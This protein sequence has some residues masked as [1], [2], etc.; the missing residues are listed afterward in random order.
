MSPAL[1]GVYANG[2]IDWPRA[3]LVAL[4]L[5]VAIA[6]VVT[7]STST[8]AFSPYNGEWDGVADFRQQVEDDPDL[9]GVLLR[10]AR[11]YDALEADRT[12]AF[13]VAPEERYDLRETTAVR[14]F[15]ERGGTLVILENFGEPGTDL[16]TDVGANA[17]ITGD[18]VRDERH[19]DRGP[20]MPVATAVE[21]HSLTADVDRVTLNYASTVEPNGASVLVETSEFAYVGESLDPSALAARPVATVE[22]V[23]DGRVVVVSDPSLVT[24]AMYGE[25]DNA[26]F[27]AA[28][29]DGSEV[30]ALDASRERS[31]PA[32]AAAALTVGDSPLLQLL[33]GVVGIAGVGVTA[34]GR[35]TDA[36]A[37]LRR[38][39]EG[40]LRAF[41]T[42]AA[43]GDATDRTDSPGLSRGDRVAFLRRCHPEWDEA[44]IQRVIAAMDQTEHPGDTDARH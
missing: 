40:R 12:T 2:S 11:E 15:T 17:R 19:H 41:P 37:A 28:L 43:N 4:S 23:G 32:L 30:V 9:E 39:L 21:N 22:P 8:S 14:E 6:L 34:S 13:V 7:A 31:L 36:L 18:V 25:S 38:R 33:V 29:T 26:A 35:T 44:R 20:A 27:L 16:L 24:N 42:D 1:A 5:T 10:D 3:L